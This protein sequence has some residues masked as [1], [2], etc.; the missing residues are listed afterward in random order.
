[1]PIFILDHY[2]KKGLPVPALRSVSGNKGSRLFTYSS[3]SKSTPL[4]YPPAFPELLSP[5]EAL[6]AFS[7]APLSKPRRERQPSICSS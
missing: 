5:V 3:A 1:M 2:S 6:T 4:R 7:Q